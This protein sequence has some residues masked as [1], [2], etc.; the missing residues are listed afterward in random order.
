[1]RRKN[2]F[3]VIMGVILCFQAGSIIA[4]YDV[5]KAA[6]ET[7]YTNQIEPMTAG[8]VKVLSDLDI[9]GALLVNGQP[10]TGSYW[11]LVG[12]N[13][14]FNNGWVGV[15][16]SS[17]K[18]G[19]DVRGNL[20]L[21]DTNGAGVIYF[22]RTNGIYHALFIR[23]DDDPS[24]YEQSSEM[25]II[26]SDGRVGIGTTSP[27]TMLH[28][29]GSVTAEDYL[30]SD[31]SSI[32]GSGKWEGTGDIYYTGGNVGIGT[33][34]PLGTLHVDGSVATSGDGKNIILKAQD[35][36]VG[37]MTDGGNILLLPG[38]AGVNSF[39]DGKVGIGTNNPDT[40]L[41]VVS[42]KDAGD[43]IRITN[44]Q[45]G[46]YVRLDMYPPNGSGASIAKY[47][48]DYGPADLRSTLQIHN[49]DDPDADMQIEQTG[50]HPIIISAG[51]TDRVEL[52]V[53]GVTGNVGI[54]TKAPSEKLDVN[55]NIR[56]NGTIEANGN[57]NAS[58]T[59]CDVNGC[60][61]GGGVPGNCAWTGY[62]GCQAAGA[63]TITCPSTKFV[64]GIQTTGC[65]DGGCDDP[66]R[67][68]KVRVYCCDIT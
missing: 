34:S 18:I 38:L 58:G 23:S 9:N 27:R 67:C 20:N 49:S 54:D 19:L 39:F 45:P 59:I 10:F 21:Q 36:A 8:D 51:Y 12:N 16:T 66:T 13:I 17:P 56:A 11:S 1:M 4:A 41:H 61:G 32:S 14:Y 44:T 60:I 43:G 26:K 55:G 35:G 25:M 5:T 2:L 47:P 31:G 7:L 3:W 42:N 15:G 62:S 28:V 22:P 53:D 52:R 64:N 29:N 30:L 68:E 50:D 40:K 46:S 63:R 65:S 37:G 33:G 24:S 57:I 48:I 6:H